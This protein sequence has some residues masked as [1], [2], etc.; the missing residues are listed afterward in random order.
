MWPLYVIG[1]AIIVG[2]MLFGEWAAEHNAEQQA[3]RLDRRKRQQQ[4][5]E[6]PL[7]DLTGARAF[8]QTQ[9]DEVGNYHIKGM[10]K[11]A[12]LIAR[13]SEL[14]EDH[15]LVL[16]DEHNQEVARVLLWDVDDYSEFEPPE[17]ATN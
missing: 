2:K 10:P 8:W 17:E 15:F 7:L 1:G 12:V 4:R 11:S 14:T 3:L 6:E 9:V 13:L 16:H 5:E